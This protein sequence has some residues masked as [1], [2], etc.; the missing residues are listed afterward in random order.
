MKTY[1]A[2]PTEVTRDWHLVDAADQ[3]LGRLSTII[4]THLMG[5]HKPIYTT[6]IDC[7]DN[8]V[9]VNAAKI[10]VTGN[11]LKSKSYFHHSGYP[12]GIKEVS[13]SDELAKNP[14]G[15]ILRAVK[16]MLPANRLT[17]DRLKRLKIYAD[18][19]HKH[20]PQSPVALAIK[21]DN[22]KG[23]K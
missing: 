12:G 4:A 17:D 14:T 20:E 1:S 21:T 23:A 7:G 15:I 11:K 13:L 22:S 2:K 3:T 18:S 16:G 19:E 6:H 8:V 9:V 10:R 5:K